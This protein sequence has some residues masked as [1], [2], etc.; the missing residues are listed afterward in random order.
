MIDVTLD[1][2]S[3]RM[4]I[5]RL[6]TLARTT[7]DGLGPLTMTEMVAVFGVVCGSPPDDK[8][9]VLLQRLPGLGL[10]DSS[11]DTRQFID[12]QFVDAARAGDVGRFIAQPYS[13]STFG[14]NWN[15]PLGDLGVDVL[16]TRIKRGHLPAAGVVVALREAQSRV[17][18]GVLAADLAR[19]CIAGE[20]PV[21]GGSGVFV[22]EAEIPGIELDETSA[23]LS[24]LEFQDCIVHV[25]ELDSA[26]VPERMP[27]FV[28]CVIG[29]IEGRV[30][31]ADLPKGCFIDCETEAFGGSAATTAGIMELDL[32]PGARVAL[33]ILKKLHLQPGAGRKEQALSRGLDQA[34][35]RLVTDVLQL[36]EQH[37]LAV[38]ARS[39]G[40]VIWQ[41]VR[42]EGSRV[43]RILTAPMASSDPLIEDCE[44]L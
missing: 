8:G 1:G 35:R 11:Q 3:V 13:D 5:E 32:P 6:S 17:G 9:G 33:S 23:D 43:H 24:G 34:S 41:T 21:A 38:Q 42:S 30:G 4:I 39:G 36:I 20:I 7:A 44:R 19:I 31:A 40:Q 27:R 37:G 12:E 22:R 29:S 16:V 26:V 10:R 2:V 15:I 25:L 18:C 28:R 14:A